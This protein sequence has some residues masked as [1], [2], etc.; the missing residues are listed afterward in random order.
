M[1]SNVIQRRI[2]E[3]VGDLH[4]SGVRVATHIDDPSSFVV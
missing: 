4:A 1:L 3:L 2:L